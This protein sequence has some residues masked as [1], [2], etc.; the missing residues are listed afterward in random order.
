MPR[1]YA[2]EPLARRV[3][4][5]WERHARRSADRLHNVSTNQDD[6]GQRRSTSVHSRRVANFRPLK[7]LVPEPQRRQLVA[8]SGR[9]RFDSFAAHRPH[10][11]RVIRPENSSATRLRSATSPRTCCRR[12]RGPA[13]RSERC[14]RGPFQQVQ[15]ARRLDRHRAGA[16]RGRGGVLGCRRPALARG[17]QRP[18]HA[19]SLGRC[20]RPCP[21]G[22]RRPLVVIASAHA[23]PLLRVAPGDAGS[24]VARDL[25]QAFSG[26]RCARPR[27][28]VHLEGV[29]PEVS[30]ARPALPGAHRCHGPRRRRRPH[31]AGTTARPAGH[32]GPRRQPAHHARLA[33]KA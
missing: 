29:V 3:A 21:A 20:R 13:S 18:G 4:L 11:V 16:D 2:R 30:P 19:S 33:G 32:A 24:A 31:G 9:I 22:H 23:S 15:R 6:S 5:S 17:H 25:L 12:G 26:L 1:R 8:R 28:R 7:G 27:G 14:R 10:I